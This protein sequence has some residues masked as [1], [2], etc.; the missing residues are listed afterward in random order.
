M[1]LVFYFMGCVDE[2][3]GYQGTPTSTVVS[4]TLMVVTDTQNFPKQ[5]HFML[6]DGKKW[7]LDHVNIG[8]SMNFKACTLS[9]LGSGGTSACTQMTHNDVP[10]KDPSPKWIWRTRLVQW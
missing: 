2:E 10:E 1:V 8:G 4:Y 5:V 7:Y 3:G 9:K 6:V